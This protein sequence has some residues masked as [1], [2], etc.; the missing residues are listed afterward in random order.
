[1]TWDWLRTGSASILTMGFPHHPGLFLPSHRL[2]ISLPS[3]LCARGLGPKYKTSESMLIILA[4]NSVNLCSSI[5][6][7][8]PESGT[9]MG[10]MNK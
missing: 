5:P 1:M 7:G 8:S 2:L 3:C 6:F 10:D 4:L 9:S